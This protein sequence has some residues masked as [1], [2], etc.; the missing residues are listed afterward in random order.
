ME[1]RNVFGE[2]KREIMG[3]T[4]SLKGWISE[5]ID[6]QLKKVLSVTNFAFLFKS[7]RVY[8]LI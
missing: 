8:P 3:F 4:T 1:H 5:A 2:E 6:K 7:G